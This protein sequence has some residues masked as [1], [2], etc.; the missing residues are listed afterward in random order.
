MKSFILNMI[1]CGFLV[2][3][4]LGKTEPAPRAD[5]DFEPTHWAYSSVFGT[6]FYQIKDSRSVFVLRVPPRQSLRKSSISESG[7]RELG[8]EIKYPL[9]IGLHDIEDLTGIIDN[10]N[11][12]TVSFTPGVELEIPINPR[13]YLRPFAHIGWGK[14]LD[15]GE[16]AWIYYTGIKS[17][18][19]FPARKNEWSLLNSLYYAGYTPDEGRSDQLAV[20]ELG[21]E[22]RQ[23]LSN[24]K[25]LGRPIDLRWSLMFSF[26][27][28]ELQF[29]QPDGDFEPIKNQLDFGLA[30]SFRDG[31]LEFWIFKIHQVGLGYRI[32]SNG[33]FRAITFNMRSWFTK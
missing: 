9:T 12:G 3:P 6:G 15:S 32:S 28:N 7:E 11:F 18:Y 27:S 24:A 30:M 31:P 22:L 16:S 17:R 33:Q 1:V 25:V 26:M 29:N 13:W 8:I 2:F 20:A 21:V 10:D 19:T 14:E 4:A 5:P 23:P